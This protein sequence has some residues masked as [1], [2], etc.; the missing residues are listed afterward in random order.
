VGEKPTFFLVAMEEI[1]QNTLSKLEKIA[2]P[3]I[4]GEGLDLYDIEYKRESNGW[5]VRFYLFKEGE[6]VKIADCAKVSRQLNVL[7]DVE[8]VIKHPYNLEVS[9]PGLTRSLKK[10]RH[11][12]KSTGSLV[13]IKTKELVDNKKIITGVLEKVEGEDIFILE[14]GITIKIQFNNINAAKLEIEI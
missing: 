5:V 14:N 13:K 9:S 12:E 1:I 8:D 4:E 6:G 11:F 2:L 3:V 10:L 7:L